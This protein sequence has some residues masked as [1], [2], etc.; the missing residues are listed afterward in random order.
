MSIDPIL[1]LQSNQHDPVL[2]RVSSHLLSLLEKAPFKV[3]QSKGG[4]MSS[5]AV[6]D[7]WQTRRRH[8]GFKKNT[9]EGLDESIARLQRED[10]EVHLVVIDAINYSASVWITNDLRLQ[11]LILYTAEGPR[12]YL[13]VSS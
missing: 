9:F 13:P 8:K 12:D 6:A 5:K 11:A 1:L 4:G 2:G 7:I 10:V 3:I